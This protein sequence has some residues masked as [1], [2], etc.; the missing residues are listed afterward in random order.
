ME[1][2]IELHKTPDT[3]AVGIGGVVRHDLTIDVRRVRLRLN[4]EDVQLAPELRITRVGRKDAGVDGAFLVGFH[5][6]TTIKLDSVRMAG[7]TAKSALAAAVFAAT[8]G[9]VSHV[10]VG[11][12]V[13]VSDGMHAS[14]NV[15]SELSISIGEVL[16]A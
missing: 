6:F 1:T 12:R 4:L 10:V 7:T 5:P 15:T 14:I 3:V 9:D 16:S 8:A 11:G 13:V 2:G